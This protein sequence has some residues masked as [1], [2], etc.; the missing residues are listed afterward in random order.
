M[1]WAYLR[2]LIVI[3]VAVAVAAPYR[4]LPATA[5]TPG[6]GTVGPTSPTV[7]W[8]GQTYVA[9]ATVDPAACPD[10]SVDSA[11]L[12]CDHFTFT[13]DV[14]PSYWD[15][16]IGGVEVAITWADSSN[17]F[18]LYVY[19]SSGNLAGSSASGGTT[20]ERAFIQS[21]SG[22]YEVKVLPWS[23]V[24][25]GYDGALTFASQAGGPAPNPS[26][27]SGGIGFG[28]ATI[29]DAQRT[30]G[31][32]INY[33]DKDGNYWQSGPW[34]T[35]TQQSF[36]HR[37]TDGGTQFNITSPIGL[38]QDLPP[39]GGDTDLTTDDQGYAYFV[40]LEGLANLGTAVSN[41]NGNTWR[42]N[43]LSTQDTADDRQ[44]ITMDNGPTAAASDNTVFL[45]YRQVALGSYI[46]SSP[47]STGVTDAVG[48]L[49]YQNSSADPLSSVSTG[50]P[51]G[52]IR[53]D[54]VKRNLYY[55]CAA[56]DHVALTVGHVNP[57]QRTGI[58]YTTVNTPKS[59]GGAVGDIFPSVAVDNAG[60]VYAVWVD[61]IDHNVYYSAS[62]DAGQTW[63]PVRQ[64]NGNDANSNVFPWAVAG[65][66]GN[67]AV[68]WY[69]NASHL[70]SDMMPSWYNNRQAAAQYKWYGY[71]SLVTGA[72]GSAPTFYQQRFTEKPM[73]YGQICNGGLGCTTSGGDRTM[74][75]FFSMVLDKEG[76]VRIVYSD[77]T[78]Q[79]H[80]SHVYEMRQ[81]AGPTALGTTLSKAVPSNP[82]SDPAGD[83]QS[84]HYAPV[85]G[86]GSNQPQLDFTSARITQPNAD[87]LRVQMTVK[88]LSSL[89]PPPGK[90]SAVWLTRF[91]ALSVGDG[92][93]ESY[94]FFYVGAESVGGG[95][96]SFFSGSG[97]SSQGAVPGNGC[98][99]TTPGTCKVVQY[100]AEEAAK[101]SISGNT[102]T[103]EVP[104]QG[105]FG[106]NRPIYGDTLYNVTALSYGRNNS[107]TDLYTDVDATRSFDY[108]LGSAIT[109]PSGGDEGAHVVA[110][111]EIGDGTKLGVNVFGT[112]AGKVSYKDAA[113][114]VDFRSTRI[115]SVQ[116]DSAGHTA[117]I[118]GT[119]VNAGQQVEFTATAADSS[120][121]GSTD[122]F[123]ISLDSGYSRSGTLT[124]GNVNIK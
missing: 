105:G 50:A 102:I 46:L 78:S 32:P 111:G 51:C 90:T 119:G 38:R 91:Q 5:A 98:T 72:A 93:E 71:M 88:D 3:A 42:K 23:V 112:P 60:N 117:K 113:A 75:D 76:A 33:I 120:K 7:K 18:D 15:S 110:N 45:A 64:V 121:D 106:A 87:T 25:S 54:P 68:A 62:T 100:P 4:G 74:A 12:I 96:P 26:R 57:G 8:A 77:T 114:G 49:V 48:G 84:P 14:A 67:L 109:P 24:S 82:M 22:T 101:G 13:V 103:I 73:H 123:S 27:T 108:T 43:A 89:A 53:F 20:S 44:W 9:G 1:R 115:T 39:G 59:P 66:D 36:L 85:T 30:E 56:G 86:P 52:Q 47:G 41:D 19:D 35:T 118:S 63:G 104:V 122:T 17:D 31:E 37:S 58:N 21:P 107:L 11:N 10:K 69:G 79:H 65:A 97:T 94:R 80:G 116:V 124:K 2:I 83:A 28:P 16:N 40:D 99:N 34:G 29:V 70:D 61:E 6:S 92:G 55:P 95:A 81:L